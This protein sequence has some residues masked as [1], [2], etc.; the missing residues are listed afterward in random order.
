MEILSQLINIV[1][2]NPESILVMR[3]QTEQ[4]LPAHQHDKAQ[5]LLVYGGIAYL[6]TDTKDFYIPSNHYIWIPKNYP[7]NLMFNTQDLYIINIYFPD[8]KADSFYDE[9]GIYPVSK[10]LAEMLSFSEKWQGDYYEGSW[11]FEFLTTLKS[12][13]SKENLKKFSIQLP[14]TDDQ[15]L[16]A[17]IDGFRNRLNESLSLDSIAQQSGISVRSLTRLFQ[18][19]LH[20]TFVQYLKM[21]RI[22]RAMELINDTDLNMTEIAYEIGYSNISAFSNNFQQLTNMRPTEFKT[23]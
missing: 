13:L 6:Q 17:I 22:I 1:D 12:L 7:H 11:E 8:E 23:K 18:T 5:L 19:K 16:N 9:L 15:R 2:Q 3:Q 20:I 4:R 14:T 10:L 21:L